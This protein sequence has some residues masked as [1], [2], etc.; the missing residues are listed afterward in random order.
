M[1]F[2]QCL[3][4]LQAAG[5]LLHQMV[6][7]GGA[8]W[9]PYRGSSLRGLSVWHAQTSVASKTGGR[10]VGVLCWAHSVGSDDKC[11]YLNVVNS[12]FSFHLHVW[13]CNVIKVVVRLPPPQKRLLHF[14]CCNISLT[15]VL[16]FRTTELHSCKVTRSH[17]PYDH[18]HKPFSL[19]IIFVCNQSIKKKKEIP[20][21]L[22]FCSNNLTKS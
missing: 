9:H 5:I 22:V 17:L 21:V 10:E 7:P 11:I 16:H 20:R 3:S 1:S 13:R 19:S 12:C 2:T 6:L 8:A 18:T 4:G 14:E 15:D